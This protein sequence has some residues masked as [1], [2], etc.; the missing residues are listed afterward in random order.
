MS[1]PLQKYRLDVRNPFIRADVRAAG[2]T[3]KELISRRYQKVFYNLYVSADVVNDPDQ[4]EPGQRRQMCS[5]GSLPPLT[6]GSLCCQMRRQLAAGG[7]GTA[8]KPR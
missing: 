5:S 2:I 8:A 4:A 3:V 7:S 6:G 1:L